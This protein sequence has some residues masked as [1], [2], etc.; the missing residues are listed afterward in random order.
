MPNFV[1]IFVKPLIAA[2]FCGAA[3]IGSYK[4]FDMIIGGKV[5]TILAVGAAALVYVAA[6]FLIKAVDEEDIKMLPKGQKIYSVLC[7]L[8]IFK[9]EKG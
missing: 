5:S 2:S 3:A 6:M 9:A 4:L 7:R 8:H 1:K